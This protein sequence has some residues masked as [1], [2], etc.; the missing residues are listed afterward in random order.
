[1]CDPLTL[2]VGGLNVGATL[3]K[4]GGSLVEGGLNSA[5]QLR[6]AAIARGNADIAQRRGVLRENQIRRN[7]DQ[8]LNNQTAHFAAAG[9]DPTFGS[10]LYLL[11]ASA[12]A[13]EVDARLSR[14]DTAAEVAGFLSQASAADN[15]AS[16]DRFA[17]YFGAGTALLTGAAKVF[18]DLPHAAPAPSPAASPEVRFGG[19]Y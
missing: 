18:S 4:A 6:A 3:F 9:V 13:G 11:A 15:A 8:V 1:M 16:A 7:V 17:G 2:I 12:A 5:A 14:A 10:P 19:L